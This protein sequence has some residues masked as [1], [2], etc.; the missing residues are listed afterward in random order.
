[1][2]EYQQVHVV[3]FTLLHK[4]TITIPHLGYNEGLSAVVLPQ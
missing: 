1:M 3:L 2:A 4:I